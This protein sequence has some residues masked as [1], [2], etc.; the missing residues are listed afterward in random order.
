MRDT[1][2]PLEKMPELALRYCLSHPAVSSVIPGMRSAKHVAANVAAS[3]AGVLPQK[4]L[5]ALRKYRWVRNF[6]S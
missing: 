5:D 2:T 1:N 4:T 3:D 6:Y